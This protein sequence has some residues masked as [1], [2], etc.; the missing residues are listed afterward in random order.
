MFSKTLGV[1]VRQSIFSVWA[2]LAWAL[3]AAGPGATI[4][5]GDDW[6]QWRGPDR[7]DRSNETGLLQAWP[8][9]GPELLWRNDNCGLGY[10]GFS[11]VG[12]R[13]FTM[14]QENQSQFVVCLNVGDGKELWRTPIG[15]SFGN[16][17]G[18][19]P[20]ST[21]TVDQGQ[22]FALSAD[23]T[24]AAL[25]AE[26]GTEQWSIQLTDFG[27]NVPTWGYSESVL[28]DGDQ[29]IC[30]P[31]GDEGALLA[32][33]RATG[34]KIWQSAQVT[35]PPHY[36]SPSAA[37]IGGRRQ[38]VQLLVNAVVGID[39]E[40][41]SLIWQS[42]WPGRTAVIPSPI[43]REDSVYVTSGYGVGCKRLDIV[44]GQAEAA[45]TNKVMKNHHGGV[46]LIDDH[47][48]GYSDD[49]GWT[50]QDWATG[51]RVWS[52]KR[53]GKGAIGYAD[54]RLYCVG[55][56]SGE[57]VLIEPSPEGWQE[58]G[59]FT[60]S[61]QTSRRKSDGRI[62]VHPVIANGRLY[63]RDQEIV[64]CFDIRK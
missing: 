49:A 15:G 33:E 48:Y 60:L 29:V 51:E 28:V 10:S 54:G 35:A 16:N 42:D 53:L 13:L 23:G 40:S 2:L 57:V 30:T 55:E 43:I 38:V 63:L 56:S 32:V 17:W 61:P 9:R 12:D 5:S 25:S 34:K 37:T 62:W 22:V 8:D 64:Y 19:G 58:H 20:R 3:V 45:W 50:C 41:G 27:G 24:L 59:R 11:V 39:A 14:G 46:I 31:G 52:E 4:A 18:D 36:A 7:N 21:P 26:N 6:P 47:L 44:D 1:S